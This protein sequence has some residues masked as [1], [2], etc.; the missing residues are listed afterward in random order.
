MRRVTF[1][2]LTKAGRGPWQVYADRGDLVVV[3]PLRGRTAMA[4]YSQEGNFL[5][6]MYRI[7]DPSKPGWKDI[8][9]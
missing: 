9:T 7:S 6:S 2:G 4:A 5:R 3:G 8:V 1:K